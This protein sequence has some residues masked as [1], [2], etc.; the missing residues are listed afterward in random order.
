MTDSSR[1]IRGIYGILPGGLG[2]SELLLKAEAALQGGVK[3][4][5]LR[6]K[7]LGYKDSLKRAKRLCLLTKEYN[8]RFIVNDSL[9][10]AGE[11]GADG[12]HL[13]RN[14]MQSI[15]TMRSEVGDD[16][17]I[18]IS[19]QADA[20]FAQYVLGEGADHVSFGAIFSTDS[21]PDATPI[22]LPRLSKARQIF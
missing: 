20:A 5:Q 3:T 16:L 21:K 10:L 7:G 8:A 18:G 4:L 19:C 22:G 6:D 1:H 14:D 11:S 15:A 17:L 2:T 12:V 13:G 9:Q